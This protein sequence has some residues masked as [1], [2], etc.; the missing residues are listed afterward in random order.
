MIK[1]TGI[2][3][4]E[5]ERIKRAMERSPKFI[6]R[7]FTQGEIILLK[8]NQLKPSSVAGFFAAKEAVLKALGTGL[9]DIQW[10]DIEIYKD[11]L[12]KPYIKL[13]NNALNIAYSR[14]ITE[15][16]ISISHSRGDA[17]AQAIAT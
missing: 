11:E 6:E 17:I 16:H 4:I 3:I 8:E 1:G 15:I 7:L 14:D 12:G 2:D 13:H 9:R 5:I 10:R